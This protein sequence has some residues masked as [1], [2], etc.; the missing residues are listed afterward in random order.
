M[1]AERHVG[2]GMIAALR[3]AVAGHEGA[4]RVASAGGVHAPQ[5]GLVVHVRAGRGRLRER[6]LRGG[7][8]RLDPGAVRPLDGLGVGAQRTATLEDVPRHREVAVVVVHLHHAPAGLPLAGALGAFGLGP[9][10]D[11]GSPS[12]E[13]E[14]SV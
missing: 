8:L 14:T 12:P 1:A 5:Q 6:R 9:A 4:D 2:G 7:P 11:Q 3:R 10:E 13:G